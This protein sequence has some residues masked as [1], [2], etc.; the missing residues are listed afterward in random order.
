MHIFPISI[1]TAVSAAAAAAYDYV[2]S[3]PVVLD[4]KY[5]DGQKLTLNINITSG[6]EVVAASP[7]S[8]SGVLSVVVAGSVNSGVTFV[9]LVT[10]SGSSVILDSGT[11]VTKAAGSNVSGALMIPLTIVPASGVTEWLTGI[12][13]LKFG[14][15]AKKNDVDV[16]M[17]LIAG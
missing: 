2:W 6:G 9:P 16:S 14:T 12:P 13:Y 10:A 1:T 8:A 11:S 17:F 7:S 15:L 4:K 3:N 5:H